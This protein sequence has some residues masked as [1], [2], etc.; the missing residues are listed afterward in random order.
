MNTGI[1]EIVNTTNGKRYVGSAVHFGNRWSEH[2][3][4]LIGGSHGN[5]LM[6]SSWNKY[7]VSAFSFRRIL[8]C[9]PKD[10]IFYEQRCLDGLRPEYN[11]CKIAGSQ[12]G[13]RHSDETKKKMSVAH[14]G[15][16]SNLGR[17]LSVEHRSRISFGCSNPSAEKRAKMSAAGLGRKLSRK[18]CEKLV[19]SNRNR[20]WTD[21]ARA[22]IGASK[23]G[24]KY[25]LGQSPSPETRAKL[26][27]AL[28]G[29]KRGT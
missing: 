2:R 13:N 12:F 21:E 11:I 17:R 26:S 15:N 14:I 18:H 1:Y 22:K 27:A 28:R 6:Q 23:V 19:E 9:A 29:R 7:G 16:K 5:R 4:H 24:K 25:R 10:L 20:V 3:R 8:I